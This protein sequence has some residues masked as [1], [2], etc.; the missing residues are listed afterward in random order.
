MWC[1][2]GFGLDNRTW[3]VC[4]LF[5]VV[6]WFVQ[7]SFFSLVLSPCFNFSV[8]YLFFATLPGPLSF[9]FAILIRYLCIHVIGG[10][11]SLLVHSSLS[12]SPST[13]N[14]FFTTAMYTTT[15]SYG[16]PSVSLLLRVHHPSIRVPHPMLC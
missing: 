9:F 13:R 8:H 12:S 7:S 2:L 3:A 15:S 5:Y 10:P 6:Y 16:H 11:N 1:G 14:L 4:S